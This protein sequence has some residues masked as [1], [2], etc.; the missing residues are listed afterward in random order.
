MRQPAS[1]LQAHLQ[2]FADETRF[3]E[4]ASVISLL[5]EDEAGYRPQFS[6]IVRRRAAYRLIG[7]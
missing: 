5:K 6:M 3:A 2:S 7:D 4:I 1:S